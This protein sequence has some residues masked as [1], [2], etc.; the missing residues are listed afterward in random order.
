MNYNQTDPVQKYFVPPCKEGVQLLMTDKLATLVI[1]AQKQGE[2]QYNETGNGHIIQG[3]KVLYFEHQ[4]K[5]RLFELKYF[6]R[7]LLRSFVSADIT[8]RNADT[9]ILS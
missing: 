7:S 6:F 1:V 8:L 9:D 5:Q 3:L 2:S 4:R